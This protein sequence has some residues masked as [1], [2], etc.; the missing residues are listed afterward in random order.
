MSDSTQPST[1]I[2][3]RV[4]AVIDSIRPAL[5]RDGGGIDLVDVTDDGVVSVKLQGACS[6]CPSAQMTLSMLVERKLK[7][8][9]PEV[10][11]LVSVK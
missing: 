6:G 1:T 10:T 2:K 3:Q 7:A 8:E 5:Q 4:S 11:K 9:V